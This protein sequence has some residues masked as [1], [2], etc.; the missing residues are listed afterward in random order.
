MSEGLASVS[1]LTLGV[2]DLRRSR[3]FYAS[4]G[5]HDTRHSNDDV[6][7]LAGRNIVLGLYGRSALAKDASVEDQPTGFTGVAFA[8]NLESNEA[9]DAFFNKATASGATPTKQPQK[10]FWGGYSGYF[11]DPDGHLWEVAHN[12]FF[13]MDEQGQLDL[14]KEKGS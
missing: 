5:W 11:A 7:F 9:V 14:L 8:V 3:D 6:K 12:P 4:L 13:V 10:V 1:I 2:A